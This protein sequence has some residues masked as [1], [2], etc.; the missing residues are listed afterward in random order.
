MLASATSCRRPIRFYGSS[1]TR[2]SHRKMAAVATE[3][4]S[5]SATATKRV[6][7]RNC[8][9]GSP[10]AQ[11]PVLKPAPPIA[12]RYKS[13]DGDHRRIRHAET[14]APIL[15]GN[16]RGVLLHPRLSAIRCV[17][18]IAAANAAIVYRDCCAGD[19]LSSP[20]I[21]MAPTLTKTAS[22]F[23]RRWRPTGARWEA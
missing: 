7:P 4:A 6:K 23:S 5:Q 11:A 16:P 1:A 8:S 12:R 9:M 10:H 14:L 2:G 18:P 17:V 15:L 19:L 20:A 3:C 13:V 22:R 21:R